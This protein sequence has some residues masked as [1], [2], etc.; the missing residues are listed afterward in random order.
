MYIPGTYYRTCCSLCG[1]GSDGRRHGRGHKHTRRYS[2][3]TC[4]PGGWGLSWF[5]ASTGRS[6]R[7]TTRASLSTPLPQAKK[8]QN[9]R[10]RRQ[11]WPPF[12]AFSAAAVHPYLLKLMSPPTDKST[13]PYLQPSANSP[14]ASFDRGPCTGQESTCC[15]PRRWRVASGRT[16]MACASC[17]YICAGKIGRQGKRRRIKRD[18]ATRDTAPTLPLTHRTLYIA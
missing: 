18:D 2:R 1:R 6:R 14:A 7:R 16:S 13:P 4:P 8:K 11:A 5:A 10:E 15:R 12:K 9:L 3:H 17:A